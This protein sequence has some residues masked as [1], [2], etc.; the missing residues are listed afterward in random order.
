MACVVARA[1]FVAAVAFVCVALWVRV[2]HADGASLDGAWNMSAVTVTFTV[3][4]WSAPCG[5]AP[6]SR[7]VEPAGPATVRTD[8]SE[9]VIANNGHTYR[10]DQCLDDMSTLV[11][12]AH[13]TDG[14]TWRTR[15]T[16]PPSDPRRAIV[17]AAYFLNGDSTLSVAETGRYEFTIEGARCVADVTRQASLHKVVAAAPV[18]SG[19]APAIPSPAASASGVAAAV[20]NGGGD[21][22][23]SAPPHPTSKVNCDV[24][25]EA[26]RLEVRPSRKLLRAGDTF[27]FHASVVDEEGCPTGTAIRWSVSPMRSSD[28]RLPSTSSPSIDP[29]GKLSIPNGDVS[30]ATFDVIATADGRSARATVEVTS[31]DHYEALLTQSGLGPNG[32]SSEPAV[33]VFATSSLG[34][35]NVL[36][37]DSARRRRFLFIAI[38]SGLA[39]VLGVVAVFGAMRARRG[40]ALERAAQARHAEK[41]RQYEATKREREADHAAQV[42]AHLAQMAQLENVTR[43]QETTAN[44]AAPGGPGPGLVFCPSCRREFSDGGIYCPF[45]ANRLVSVAGHEALAAGPGGGVCPTC[46]R[47]FNPGVRVCP[48][49]GDE[50]SPA[51]MIAPR[52]PAVRG[53]ICP[54]CGGRF[55]GTAA[56]CGKDGT[57]LVLLN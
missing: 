1:A 56:F 20:G 24:P 14:R 51:A 26:A 17:N 11:R 36:A 35:A 8:G 22:G 45:D 40:R 29:G 7:T 4:Q 13:S 31:P 27:A 42:R 38:I 15:C 48:H 37:E 6:V 10:T 55:D 5:P 28:G 16:T 19:V 9:I 21:N 54:T 39:L 46:H 23:I 41:M 43:A 18:A 53:K 34:A 12:D 44:A 2:A 25:G 3:Q 33:A 57:Q 49:D 52:P 50:L 32:E 30:D 47:G